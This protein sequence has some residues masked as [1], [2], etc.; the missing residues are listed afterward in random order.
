MKTVFD[1]VDL[2]QLQEMW[3]R[4]PILMAFSRLENRQTTFPCNL[5]L[6]VSW[7][8]P[9]LAQLRHTTSWQMN[10][11]EMVRDP[12]QVPMCDLS[13]SYLHVLYPDAESPMVARQTLFNAVYQHFIVSQCQIN[14]ELVQPLLA[15]LAEVRAM[16]PHE[17]LN[18]QHLPLEGSDFW[19]PADMTDEIRALDERYDAVQPGTP[20][21]Y[22]IADEFWD[23]LVKATPE[24]I[25]SVSQKQTIQQ[26]SASHDCAEKLNTLVELAITWNRSPSVVG[27]YYQIDN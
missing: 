26:L 3:V 10:K 8:Q 25:E 4:R 24:E 2:L 15:H 20:A 1:V 16:Q 7:L 13:D 17:C 9:R 11:L 14:R 18:T 27:L 21:T 6:S 23:L 19:I 22:V 5:D 12:G